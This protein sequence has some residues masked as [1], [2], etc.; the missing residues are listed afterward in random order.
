MAVRVKCL[1]GYFI[2]TEMKVGQVSDFI[3]MTGLELVQKNNFYTFS[4]L[5]SVPEYSLAGADFMGVT[6]AE[7]YEGE[8]WEIFQANGLVYNF[9]T[10]VVQTISSITTRSTLK[11]AG[12]RFWSPGLILPGTLME[13]GLRVKDY[14]AWFSRD[15]LKWLYTDVTYV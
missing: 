13:S 12:N 6:A 1:H 3:S 11:K 10:G 2:F 8:P 9:S 5:N 7:N 15:T 4:G 14:A